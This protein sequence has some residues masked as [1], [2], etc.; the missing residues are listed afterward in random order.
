MSDGVIQLTSKDV[1]IIRLQVLKFHRDCFKASI[2]RLEKS[3]GESIDLPP[4]T[5]EG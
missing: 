1:F 3:L 4:W 2:F 5:F